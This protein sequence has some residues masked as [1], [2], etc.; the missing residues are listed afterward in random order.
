MSY[1]QNNLTHGL[2]EMMES[3]RQ[4]SICDGTARESKEMINSGKQKMH[5][6]KCNHIRKMGSAVNII[7]LVT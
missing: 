7:P 6:R 4:Q 3:W 5:R 2:D 1:G